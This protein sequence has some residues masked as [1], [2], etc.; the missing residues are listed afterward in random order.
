MGHQPSQVSQALLQTGVGL[1]YQH[2]KAI[3]INGINGIVLF[4]FV[5]SIEHF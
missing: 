4:H 2:C 1:H 5:Y 3:V